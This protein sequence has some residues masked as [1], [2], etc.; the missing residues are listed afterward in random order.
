M[1]D[2]ASQVPRIT[3][4]LKTPNHPTKIV[5]FGDSV[6][7]V[8]YHTGGR[9]AYTKM[10]E[11]ALKKAYPQADVTAVNAGISG[12]T[13]RHGLA[14]I[15]KDVLA[16]KPDLVTVM[17]GLNDMTGVPLDDYR[18]NLAEIIRRNRDTGNQRHQCEGNKEPLHCCLSF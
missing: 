17:F 14:R 8:Y 9:R 16:H 12:N 10:V 1:A 6:T 5:C 3:Q 2:D 11:I 4:R 7:G 15:E 13:T 18:K